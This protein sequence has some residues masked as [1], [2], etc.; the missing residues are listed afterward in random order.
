MNKLFLRLFV[1]IYAPSI[2]IAV[3][4]VMVSISLPIYMIY[5]KKSFLD[6]ALAL[7]YIN[8]G[9]LL[10]DPF[11]GFLVKRFG[12]YG[13]NILSLATLSL[14]IYAL[15]LILPL[16]IDSLL[17]LSLILFGSGRSIWNISRRYLIATEVPREIRGRASSFIG[18]SER[19]GLFIGPVLVGFILSLWSY[20]VIYLLALLLGLVALIMSLTIGKRLTHESNL[21]HIDKL[22]IRD[23]Q[24]RSS[25]KILWKE[26]I[27][28]FAAMF[29]IQGIRSVRNL[30]LP[31][32]G[33]NL[34][35]LDKSYV[36]YLIGLSGL[37][38]ILMSYPSGLLMDKRGRGVAVSLSF[39][40]IAVAYMVLT[41]SKAPEI[42]VAGLMIYGLGNGLGAGTMI[43]I[44]SDVSS[45]VSREKIHSFLVMWQTISDLSTIVF[46]VAIGL[47]MTI[48]GAQLMCIVLAT[49][50]ITAVVLIN[51]VREEF[52]L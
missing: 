45:I 32:I 8:L 22:G 30:V 2:I 16:N 37:F 39:S 44:G 10:T 51:T 38:D 1:E 4:R 5:E 34:A 27:I 24:I 46:P 21:S 28:L 47:A 29:I 50:S 14:S 31:S 17:I 7:T 18:A 41:A 15:Y 3:L 36:S 11:T 20:D 35:R 49:L 25:E 13:T 23:L 19:V 48:L 26:L 42:Y 40:I 9:S 33:E 52:Y 43:T 6:A 12:S